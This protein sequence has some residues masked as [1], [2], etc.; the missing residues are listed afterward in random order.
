M[1]VTEPASDLMPEVI[2]LLLDAL[3]VALSLRGLAAERRGSRMVSAENSFAER[4]SGNPAALLGQRQRQTVICLVDR[5]DRL[6][7]FWVQHRP[8]GCAA[9]D[10]EYLGPAG[11]IRATADRIARAL[12]PDGLWLRLEPVK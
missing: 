9:V 7:W 1:S 11:Y 6:S 2:T 12:L 10:L 4:R 5:T 8:T 3:V